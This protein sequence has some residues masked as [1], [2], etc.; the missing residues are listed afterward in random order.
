MEKYKNIL[1][2]PEVDPRSLSHL[3]HSPVTIPTTLNNNNNNNDNGTGH[4]GRIRTYRSY[5]AVS[6]LARSR[7][8]SLELAPGLRMGGRKGGLGDLPSL[9][10]CRRCPPTVIPDS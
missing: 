1:P 9:D 2:L 8:T 10:N 3:A 6:V 5:V 4:S 7:V